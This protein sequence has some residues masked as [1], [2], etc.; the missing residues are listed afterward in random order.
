MSEFDK[1]FAD[2]LDEEGRYPGRKRNW[3]SLSRRLDD[4]NQSTRTTTRRVRVWQAAV[5]VSLVLASLLFWKVCVLHRENTA[6]QARVNR[7]MEWPSEIQ[8][9]YSAAGDE[10]TL[11]PATALENG[12]A[13]GSAKALSA[14][15]KN[16][17]IG[18]VPDTRR[19]KEITVTRE[20]DAISGASAIKNENAGA[21]ATFPGGASLSIV[22]ENK[23]VALQTSELP[24]KD[25]VQKNLAPVF[26]PASKLRTVDQNEARIQLLPV[27]VSATSEFTKP[28]RHNYSRYRLGVQVLAGKAIPGRKGISMLTGTGVS[29]EYKFARDLRVGAMVDWLHYEVNTRH[30]WHGYHISPDPPP[31]PGNP[32]H[33]LSRV[34]G[35][36]RSQQV[37]LGLTYT[38]PVDFWLKPSV[39]AYHTWIHKS[40]AN[41]SFEFKDSHGGGP[42]G[43]SQNEYI[44]RRIKSR[45]FD[46]VWRFGLGLEHET[47]RWAFSVWADYS[48]RFDDSKLL[49]NSIVFRSGIQYK[50][51]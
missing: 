49:F 25:A 24:T 47:P 33:H 37:A 10:R 6:L 48:D 15:A 21:D 31:M 41:F 32:H 19:H 4:F 34:Q 2:K 29:F 17:G 39:R 50:F 7:A 20:H 26:L 12:N 36:R 5:V 40:P 8:A 18:D 1:F 46:Q 44:A 28:L 42:H 43:G 3:D 22:P 27:S 16:S 38:L 51:D 14:P 11:P 23:G 30:Q 35:S 13:A 9:G 45:W